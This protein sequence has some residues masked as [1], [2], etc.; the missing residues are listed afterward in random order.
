MRRLKSRE[1]VVR[2]QCYYVGVEYPLLHAGPSVSL[3]TVPIIFTGTDCIPPLAYA[4]ATL[5]FNPT[6]P[7]RTAS[8]CEIQLILP[9]KYDTFEEFKEHMNTAL[10]M[11]GG[12]CLA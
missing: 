9:T 4:S 5:T 12:F 8:T 2:K 1:T 10:R 6:N 3:K 7:Y 11:H